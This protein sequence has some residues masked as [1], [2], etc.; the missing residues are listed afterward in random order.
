MGGR[1]SLERKDE[2]GVW[3]EQYRFSL[4][5]RTLPDF[6]DM[7]HYHQTSPSSHFT[8]GP[9][10][11]LGLRGGRVTLDRKRLIVTDGAKRT[12]IE[13]ESDTEWQ[14]ILLERF[15]IDWNDLD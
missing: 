3:V 2:G 10:V 12:E 1:L 4:M 8:R 5:A 13:V 7:C 14:S 6:G 11:S 15:G 9:I